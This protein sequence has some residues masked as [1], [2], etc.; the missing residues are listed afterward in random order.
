MEA[1]SVQNG[2]PEPLELP[3]CED[4]CVFGHGLG[5]V[6]GEDGLEES[7]FSAAAETRARL[8]A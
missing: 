3:L 2:H 8:R 1:T 5:N 4:T 7:G 6:E